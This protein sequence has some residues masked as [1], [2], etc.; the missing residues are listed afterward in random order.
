MGGWLKYNSLKKGER[1]FKDSMRKK[2]KD[3]LRKINFTN[4]TYYN[5]NQLAKSVKYY[6]SINVD[7]HQNIS[8]SDNF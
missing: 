6:N 2:N 8:K 7:F 3:L 4:F 5:Y 1:I